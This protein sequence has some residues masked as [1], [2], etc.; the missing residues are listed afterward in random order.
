MKTENDGIIF[1]IFQTAT[2]KTN[3][4]M[5]NFS[6]INDEKEIISFIF[7]GINYAFKECFCFFLMVKK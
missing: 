4:F 6:M 5:N 3:N 7:L 2:I 1:F